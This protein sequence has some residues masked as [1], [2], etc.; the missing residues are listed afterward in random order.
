M[1]RFVC[2]CLVLC[3][4]LVGFAPVGAAEAPAFDENGIVLTFGVCGDIRLGGTE[5]VTLRTGTSADRFGLALQSLYA[6]GIDALLLTGDIIADGAR[7]GLAA[8]AQMWQWQRLCEQYLSEEMPVF[9]TLGESDLPPESVANWLDADWFADEADRESAAEGR[10]HCVIGGLHFLAVGGDYT[11]DTYYTADTLAWLEEQLALAAADPDAV[12]APIF[13]ITH[14]TAADTTA[15]SAWCASGQ[16]NDILAVY[17]QV[18]LFAGHTRSPLQNEK[19]IMQTAFTAVDSG[20]FSALCVPGTGYTLQGGTAEHGL[21]TPDGTDAAQG[22]YV[23][24]DAAG[25]VRITRRDFVNNTVIGQP[26]ILPAPDLAERSHLLRY[27]ADR[28]VGEAPAFPEEAAVE[29]LHSGN[30]ELQVRFAPADGAVMY[31][32]RVERADHT[33]HYYKVHAPYWKASVGQTVITLPVPAAARPCTVTV[34]AVDEWGRHGSSIHGEWTLP[35]ED[36][37]AAAAAADAVILGI[38]EIDENSGDAILTAYQA[39]RAL[40][41]QQRLLLTEWTHLREAAEAYEALFAAIDEVVYMPS[42]EDVRDPGN[43]SSLAAEETAE[44]VR[45]TFDRVA[46]SDVRTFGGTAYALDGLHIVLRDVTGDGIGLSLSESGTS[47]IYDP[48][49]RLV[50][51]AGGTAAFLSPDGG[52]EPVLCASLSP[53][54]SHIDIRFARLEDGSWQCT[55]NGQALSVDGALMQQLFG[56]GKAYVQFFAL[57]TADPALTDA[58]FTVT[59]I[60]GG[61]G[62][63]YGEKVFSR[64][65]VEAVCHDE[66]L[67]QQLLEGELTEIPTTTAPPVT[68][69]TSHTTTAPTT[70]ASRP[71]TVPATAPSTVPPTTATA[72][73]VRPTAASPSE[74][75]G[76]GLHGGWMLGIGLLGGIVLTAG[77]ALLWVRRAQKS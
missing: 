35:T 48:A 14:A 8:D 31:Q 5:G 28:P 19:S 20:S 42:L 53:L 34:T 26:W 51:A 68:T 52:T 75:G 29:A 64:C 25:A 33:I 39:V 17:P 44:G 1:R 47:S 13:V 60:H 62:R 77:A 40:T 27:R 46:G 23:E 22:L 66:A 16:L 9:Y 15:G 3:L 55:L 30:G 70:T 36:D 58:A 43:W 45:V 41:A 56:D 71:T 24:V 61:D 67:L 6:D 12:G 32:C 74:E 65:L 18:I 59:A 38:G 57:P 4:C 50:V 63:C 72:T 11:A 2:L 10:R 49:L 7:G 54:S 21:Y 76:N 37:Y 69:T 73:T